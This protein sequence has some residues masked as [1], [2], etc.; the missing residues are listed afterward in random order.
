MPV[1][2]PPNGTRDLYPIEAARRRF[3]TEAWRRV[4][5][6]HGFEEIDGPTFEHLELYTVKSGEGIVSELFS[7]RR[8][9][10]EKDFALRPEFTPTLARMYAARAG[11]LPKPTK[12]F[13]CGPFF[14][15]ERPQR[16]RLREFL[17]WNCDV[18][19]LAV[20]EKPTPDDIAM[21]KATAD[22]EVIACC[23]ELFQSLGLTS[24]QIMC[25][26]N[27]RT[28]AAK[29]IE[30][31]G[32][33]LDA[34]RVLVLLDKRAKMDAKEFAAACA[35]M[36][37]DAGKYDELMRGAIESARMGGGDPGDA[38]SLR[39]LTQR[40]DAMGMGEWCSIDA[41]I[42]RGLA[43]YTGTVF[44]IIVDGERAVAGGGRYD[45]LIELFGGPPTPAVGFGMGDVVLSLVL[46]DKGLMPTDGELLE[47]AGQ[48]PDVFVISN[49]TPEADAKLGSVVATL[50]RG[51]AKA[52][53]GVDTGGTPVPRALADRQDSGLHVRRSYKATKNV[54]K[55]LREAGD[56]RARFAVI[57]ESGMEATIKNLETGEQD[58]GRT[59][60]ERLGEELRRR[61]QRSQAP[62]L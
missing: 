5:I 35:G 13:T 48:R 38:G 49:G 1:I 22:A 40:L 21:A 14:R 37:F 2:Q 7:F 51:N 28:V 57:L 34:T 23:V 12:W 45:N 47:I 6:N 55:L 20:P 44:E 61:L 19:G 41:G 3:I 8:E 11:S 18:I 17:Q 4:A 46:Q 58:Q 42:A 39:L 31:C 9:G 27:D 52:V 10:G 43:Y 29:V 60:I 32:N 16:G 24:S 15:A 53:E 33:R 30:R 54:G 36:G 25:R 62:G 26:F 59:G 56:V 50:R